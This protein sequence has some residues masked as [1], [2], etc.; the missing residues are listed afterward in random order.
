MRAIREQIAA[1]I[2]LIIQIARFPDGKRRVTHITELT[3]REGETITTQNLF[4]FRQEGVDSTGRILG[5]LEPTGIVPTFAERFARSGVSIDLG[6]AT[7][8]MAGR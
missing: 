8:A 7:F 5:A 2:H 1:A 4:E 6:F 3:G